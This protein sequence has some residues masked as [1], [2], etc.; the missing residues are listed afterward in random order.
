MD[1]FFDKEPYASA[2]NP[3]I[4]ISIL[5][6]YIIYSFYQYMYNKNKTGKKYNRKDSDEE[7][8]MLILDGNLNLYEQSNISSDGVFRKLPQHSV[9]PAAPHPGY[10]ISE[11]RR[12]GDIQAL[13][14]AAEEFKINDYY[15]KN[16]YRYF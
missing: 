11:D 14:G 3:N 15:H 16:C 1:S 8:N 9:S 4:Y 5:A 10:L 12:D 7:Y 6:L 2:Y 13:L